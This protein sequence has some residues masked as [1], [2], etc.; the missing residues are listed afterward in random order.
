M[1]LETSIIR[2][3]QRHMLHVR[4]QELLDWEAAKG[5]RTAIADQ[6]LRLE[7]RYV[8]IH[9]LGPM[10]L[11]G[12]GDGDGVAAVAPGSNELCVLEAWIPEPH[13]LD[14]MR[15]ERFIRQVSRC[16]HRL[17]F[18]VGGNTASIQFAFIAHHEDVQLVRSVAQAEYPD[19]ELVATSLLEQVSRFRGAEL[20]LS[21][22]Y[23]QAPYTH[24]LTPPSQLH[25]SP[26]E[27]ALGVLASI[28]VEARGFLQVLAEPAQHDWHSNVQTLVNMEFISQLTA[29]AGSTSRYP[30]QT[31]T[32]DLR[33]LAEELETKAHN[34]K[35][36]FFAAV[37]V[38][39][40]WDAA[41]APTPT[42]ED[43]RPLSGF[44]GLLQM[45]GRP[46]RHLGDREY[47]SRLGNV[48][49]GEMMRRGLTYRPGFLLNS[50]E[51]AGLI[52]LPSGTM[53]KERRLPVALLETLVPD[54]DTL[55]FGTRLGQSQTAG[56]PTQVCIPDDMRPKSVHII[57][58]PGMGKSALM[59]QMMLADIQAGRGLALLDPHGDLAEDL[60]K[61]IP[62]RHVQRIVYLDMSD[63]E[64][65]PLWNP[66]KTRPGQDLTVTADELVGSIQSIVEKGHWGD[67]LAHLL[68]H[69]FV[70]LLHLQDVSLQHLALLLQSE[71]HS[72]PTR[73]VLRREILEAVTNETVK[74]FW[75]S[76]FKSYQSAEFAPVQHKLSKLLVAGGAVSPMLTQTESRLDLRG[77]MDSGQTLILNLSGIGSDTGGV[78]GSFLFSMIYL[79][80]MSRAKQPREDRRA[81][82]VY[83]DEAHLFAPETLED[84]LAQGRKFNVGVTLAHQYLRQFR[85]VQR[86]AMSS[87][88]TSITF[89]VDQSDARFLVRGLRG[90]VKDDELV[91]QGV[92]EAICR[93]GEQVV[94]IKTSM[95]PDVPARHFR[96]EI[97]QRSRD[98]YCIRAAEI[99]KRTR[100]SPLEFGDATES[101]G[102][103]LKVVYDEF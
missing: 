94:R 39:L 83:A 80:T 28:P 25:V 85:D 10:D 16:R 22:L 68:R 50:E 99:A 27:S 56:M 15:A 101:V 18:E 92:G 14:W 98:G 3:G 47:R 79:A 33:M 35:P 26:Y 49:L 58:I 84:M 86:D 91:E 21:D 30:Q 96:E 44:M 37:R 9:R 53:L 74:D 5:A 41:C 52:H 55:G 29:E 6:P 36:F 8:P 64:W 20:L 102:G 60:L 81:F 32:G 24:R 17:V 38:G 57:G 89:A 95:P 75:R 4:A 61:R 7:P 88:G 12:D 19:C 59:L 34:D 93:I 2:R 73:E 46:L 100:T 67:R 65:I 43:L 78:V 11:A 42:E 82:N 51:L 76:Q 1:G 40:E 97:I 103:P 63:S 72:G 62:E 90:K 70:G 69:G 77:F 31:P 48:V 23:P 87:A 71:R 13:A 66:L 45:G 54:D